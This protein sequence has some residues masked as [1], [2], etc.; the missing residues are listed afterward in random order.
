MLENQFPIL[1]RKIR[2]QR[3]VYLDSASTTQKP[4]QVIAAI[5]DYYERHNA[6]IHR[7]IHTLSL[8]ATSLYEGA[9]DKVQKFINA[10]SREEI[11]FTSGATESINLVVWTWG[12][13]N[14]HRGD[15]ILLTEMEHHSNLVPWQILAKKKGAKLKFIPII[16]P[17]PTPPPSRGR[18]S[19]FGSPPLVGGVREGVGRLDISNLNK[20]ITK[21]TKIVS[22][23]HV[24]NVLGTINDVVKITEAAHA[25]G[26]KVLI[27]G[28]QAGGHLKI[29]VQKI[30]CD[31]YVLSGHKMY[32]PTGVGVLYGRKELLNKMPPYQTGGHMIRRVDWTKSTWNDLPYK[33][34][35]GTANIAEVVGLGAAVDFLN[36]LPPP[37]L[38]LI[39][40]EKQK[41]IFSP[42]VRKGEIERG[43][44][45]KIKKRESQL[46]AYA[47]KK[48][49][50]VP[51][52][53]IYGPTDAKDRVGVI[54]FTLAD[55]PP[56]DLASVL[57]EKG[58]AI[59]T[60]HHCTM[61]LH[62]KFGLTGTA[63]VSLG[64]Y[65][66]KADINALIDGI[67]YARRILSFPPHI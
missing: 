58:I 65:N 29:D 15:E 51:G 23:A 57:D 11:I 54:S 7:G 32:G 14:I 20:L 47:L 39:T 12:H 35:A 53:K 66:S 43:W 27:D 28:A 33:F 59:R 17:P 34:E 36:N 38:P 8:E 45:N 61:P 30:G 37:H 6:N 19:R 1:K 9:R 25:K 44:L 26:A 3:L 56:H 18:K 67:E 2:G 21:K 55:V 41:K 49:Q 40:G 42:S 10:K 52:L 46:A 62:Q 22:V 5:S 64:I 31:F 63:R 60:G 48:L 24:S 16:S 13:E 4:R 50:A